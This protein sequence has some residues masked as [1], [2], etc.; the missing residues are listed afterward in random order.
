MF[1]PPRVSVIIPTYNR[2]SSLERALASLDFQTYP[3][4]AFD[5]ILVDDGSTDDTSEIC[6]KPR[7][8]N[9]RYIYQ[10][11]S[12]SAASRNRGAD[13]SRAE[14]LIFIDDDITVN[15][16]F[17]KGLVHEHESFQ[18][19]IAVGK[20]AFNTSD[21]TTKF[22]R[23]YPPLLEPAPLSITSDFVDFTEC[24]TFNL[25]IRKDD[26]TEIGGMQD[27]AGDGPTWWGDVDFGYRAIKSGF[28]FRR[29]ETAVCYH[30]DYSM[31]DLDTARKRAELSSEHAVLLLRKYPEL[32][33]LL[34]MFLLF[35]NLSIKDKPELTIHKLWI[36]LIS[37]KPITHS[38]EITARQLE[39]VDYMDFI[40]KDLYKW[41]LTGSRY[42]GFQR[43]LH[44]HN[45]SKPPCMP[46]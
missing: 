4:N 34:P 1:Q 19:I 27:V 28:R 41:I 33:T 29:T 20:W 45:Q 36:R 16:Q 12:G 39:K 43:G 30:W 15:S 10:S 9:V 17:I 44:E 5:V 31:E 35:D 7:E 21:F 23:L 26:F 22:A 24:L 25:S 37:S 38:F 46:G 3:T 11:N 6:K 40:L 8:Y 18:R 42:R 2:A 13:E 14:I 32:N